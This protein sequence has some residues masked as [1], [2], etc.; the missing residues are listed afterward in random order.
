[1]ER[2]QGND[3]GLFQNNFTWPFT[4]K[5]LTEV[6][7]KPLLQGIQAGYHTSHHVMG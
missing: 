2:A 6:M 1:M 4:I 5:V 7:L 3:K